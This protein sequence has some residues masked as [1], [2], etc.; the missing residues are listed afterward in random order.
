MERMDDERTLFMTGFTYM[1]SSI[2]ASLLGDYKI[3]IYFLMFFSTFFF[4]LIIYMP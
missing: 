2:E 3:I 4:R 1:V